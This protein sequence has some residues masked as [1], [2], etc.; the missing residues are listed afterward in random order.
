MIFTWCHPLQRNRWTL[1]IWG[2]PREGNLTRELTAFLHLKI[3]A[4]NTFSF[5]FGGLEGLFSGANLLLVGSV[6]DEFLYFNPPS[7]QADFYNNANFVLIK[8]QVAFGKT[9]KYFFLFQWNFRD[10]YSTQN[11]PPQK[12]SAVHSFPEMLARQRV[13]PGGVPSEK[14]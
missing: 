6:L 5:P 11:I 4:W 13:Q 7:H 14:W 12:S 2:S 10:V 1:G 9:L 8:I 3:D